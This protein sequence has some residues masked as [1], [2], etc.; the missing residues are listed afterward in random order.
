MKKYILAG[1]ITDWGA[2]H[3]VTN[4]LGPDPYGVIECEVVCHCHYPCEFENAE[5]HRKRITLYV[6]DVPPEV[7]KIDTGREYEYGL[8]GYD[9]ALLD[10]W[11]TERG[12]IRET[13]KSSYLYLTEEIPDPCVQCPYFG[14]WEKEVCRC[15]SNWEDYEESVKNM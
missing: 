9:T 1:E 3:C 12:K 4:Y 11:E 10:P 7:T 8:S 15:E 6:V 14:K 2:R 13:S 5:G